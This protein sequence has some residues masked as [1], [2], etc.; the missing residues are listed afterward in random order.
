MRLNQPSSNS[1]P[2][3]SPH[4]QYSEESPRG[5]YCCGGCCTGCVVC[6]AASSPQVHEGQARQA[7]CSL[8]RSPSQY[9][10]RTKPALMLSE[11]A[12]YAAGYR[13]RLALTKGAS[14][15]PFR[16]MWKGYQKSRAPRCPRE[17]RYFKPVNDGD[18]LIDY[19][20]AMSPVTY[21]PNDGCTSMASA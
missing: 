11:I 12:G 19:R 20:A 1:R 17:F 9:P 5:P 3:G 7:R 14:R 4:E 18:M 8:I 21:G 15:F 2:S 13:K 10:A 6:K 16:I